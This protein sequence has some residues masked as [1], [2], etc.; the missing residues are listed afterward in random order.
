[1]AND[2]VSSFWGVFKEVETDEEDNEEY[3]VIPYNI[4]GNT[5]AILMSTLEYT[6]ILRC[7]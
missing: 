3:D 7:Q 1:M 4:F 2:I 6:N 5:E